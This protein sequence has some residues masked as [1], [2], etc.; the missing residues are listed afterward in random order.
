MTVR[1]RAP[2][3]HG[4]VNPEGTRVDLFARATFHRWLLARAGQFVTL[5]LTPARKQRSQQQSSYWWAVIV[6]AFADA[7]GYEAHEH[8]AVHDELMRLLV[9]MREDSHPALPIRAS[10]RTLTVSEFNRLIEAAQILAA[11]KLGIV[12]ADPDPDWARRRH[13]QAQTTA[14]QAASYH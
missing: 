10:S 11:E 1:A 14:R 4:R 9:G 13:G 7:C 3:W 6:P 5:V 2:R 8:S 12:I